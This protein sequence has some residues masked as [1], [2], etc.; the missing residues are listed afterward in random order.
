MKFLSATKAGV[1]NLFKVAGV[2][3]TAVAAPI[4]F[5]E[6]LLF[7]GAALLSVGAWPIYPPASFIIPGAILVYVSV[8][9]TA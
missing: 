7:G 5:R 6:I 2:A 8:F 3:L 1:V 9:G 4:G